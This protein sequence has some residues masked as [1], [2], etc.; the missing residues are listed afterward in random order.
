MK[1]G[2]VVTATISIVIT[3]I[4]LDSLLLVVFARTIP[5]GTDIAGILSILV[6]SVI[7]GYVFSLKIQEESRRKAIGS[8]AIL[9]AVVFMFYAMALFANPLVSP[10]VK[11]HISDAFVTTNWTNDD[12]LNGIVMIMGLLVASAL[13]GIFVGL[14]T[15][16]MLKKPKKI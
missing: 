11:E 2:D 8:I 9:S 10:A 12:W 7:V 6:A 4:L 1:F 3:S 5:E 13:A 16:S 15:G 14:Y